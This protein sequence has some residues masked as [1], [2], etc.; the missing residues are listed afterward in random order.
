[1]ANALIAHPIVF[2]ASSYVLRT[3]IN[4]VTEDLTFSVTAGRYYWTTG[5]GQADGSGSGGV[6]DLLDRLRACI[7]THS[8]AGTVTC[9]LVNRRVRLT[10][11]SLGGIT[12]RWADSQ[13]TLN[14][15][16]FGWTAINAS[17]LTSPITAPNLPRGLWY[18]GKPVSE[19]DSRDRTVTLGGITEALSGAYRVSDFG[20][21]ADQR[22]LS[23][24]L[25]Q[26]AVALD[27]Y[28]TS[29]EPY[30]TWQQLWGSARKGRPL[31][32]YSDD[33]ATSSTDYALY[34][35]QSLADPLVRDPSTILRWAVD[36]AVARYV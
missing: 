18:A 36:L 14:P 11:T 19:P 25:L 22:T 32:F 34:R 20:V 9:T 35:L 1:M 33:A 24:R 10:S 15:T 3:T 28:A 16:I 29:T 13:T 27:E 8:E 2:S 21:S 31:R 4:A 7:A 12:L 26:R 5:D 23:F 30:G 17:V 6:G